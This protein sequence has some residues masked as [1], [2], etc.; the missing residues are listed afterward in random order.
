MR[1]PIGKL[2][3]KDEYDKL[4][5]SAQDFG[6]VTSYGYHDGLDFNL[7]SGGDTDLG[8][9]LYAVGNGKIVYYHNATH[10]T[11]NFGRHM[12]LECDTPKG[13]RWFHYAHCQEITASVK[14]VREGEIIGKLGKS[15]TIYAHLHF[16]VFKVDPKNLR[17]GI[18]TI[19]KTT[20]ELNDWWESPFDVLYTQPVVDNV[21]QW[22]KTLLQE[23][24]LS[25]EKEGDF[26]AFWEKSKKYDNEVPSLLEQVKSANEQLA[27]KSL[28]VSRLTTQNEKFSSRVDE[29]EK[30]YTD[31]K[32]EKDIFEWQAKTLSLKVEELEKGILDRENKLEALRI[33]Y[34]ALLSDYTDA[35]NWY[36]LITLGIRK[37]FGK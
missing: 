16:S 22:F 31:V 25:L 33:D 19:A 12:V 36:Q 17:N 3:T 4:W 28:E 5:Y 24:G 30:L 34:S 27:D 6:A 9:P 23:S 7:K 1:L 20:K 14:D 29:L 8:E 37:I 2:G 21:P 13:K 26:R 15:G 18:D 10:A 11:T 35:L 32:N